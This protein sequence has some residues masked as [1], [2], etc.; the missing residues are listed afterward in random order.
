MERVLRR[1]TRV[2]AGQQEN[3]LRSPV[4]NVTSAKKLLVT[5][6]SQGPTLPPAASATLAKQLTLSFAYMGKEGN[7]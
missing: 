7:N 3:A 1:E 6:L 2:F 5:G 4:P